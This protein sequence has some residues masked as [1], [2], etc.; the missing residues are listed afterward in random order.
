MWARNGRQLFYMGPA[1]ALMSVP[2][3]PGKTWTAGNP[4]KLFDTPYLDVAV[5]PTARVYDVSPDG[6]RFL[7]IKPGGTEQDA[8]AVIGQTRTMEQGLV[9]VQHW[10][11]ELKRLAPR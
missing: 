11:E 1:A 8:A 2:I 10:I 9:V 4:T 7:M 3:E 5:G 6:K